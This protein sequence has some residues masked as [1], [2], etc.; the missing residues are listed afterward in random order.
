MHHRVWK[1]VLTEAAINGEQREGSCSDGLISVRSLTNVLVYSLSLTPS[2][3]H[4]LTHTLTH[5]RLL[6]HSLT[7]L[8]PPSLPL[9]LPPSP[10]PFRN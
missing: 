5:S 1:P 10:S 4:S 8:F 3:T 2:F 9:S 7:H 6:T